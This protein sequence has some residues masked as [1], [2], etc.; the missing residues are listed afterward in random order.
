MKANEVAL[1][2]GTLRI[3]WICIWSELIKERVPEELFEDLTEAIKW[4]SLMFWNHLQLKFYWFCWKASNQICVY[5]KRR[6]KTLCM[7]PMCDIGCRKL[8]SSQSCMLLQHLFIIFIRC[9]PGLWPGAQL[10]ISLCHLLSDWLSDWVSDWL[11][12]KVENIC[13]YRC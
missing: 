4:G 5:V 9:A 12:H 13:Q 1:F 2:L 11:S 8:N 3:L 7:F 6:H 10:Y